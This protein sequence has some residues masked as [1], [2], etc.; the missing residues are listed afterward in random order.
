MKLISL[1][2]FF[3]LASCISAS[4]HSPVQDCANACNSS[5]PPKTMKVFDGSVCRCE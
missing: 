4:S 1:L 5:F 3:I 2:M